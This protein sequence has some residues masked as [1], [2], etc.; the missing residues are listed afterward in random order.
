M[1]NK[2]V[3]YQI[4]IKVTLDWAKIQKTLLQNVV[5]LESES[6]VFK[7]KQS[8][9]LLHGSERCQ[10]L[11]VINPIDLQKGHKSTSNLNLA[12]GFFFIT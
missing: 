9:Q 10:R 1:L 8:L 5:F 2:T 11:H 3:L 6:L 4:H 7:I 12:T